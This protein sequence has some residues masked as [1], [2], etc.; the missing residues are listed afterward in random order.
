MCNMTMFCVNGEIG[1]CKY[2]SW[3]VLAQDFNEAV[4][5]V[6]SKVGADNVKITEVSV[7]GEYIG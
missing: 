3:Y 2:M 6:R 4:A 5:K 1:D 7:A